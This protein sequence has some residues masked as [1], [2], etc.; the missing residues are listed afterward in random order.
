MDGFIARRRVL[1]ARYDEL[2]G[3]VS[4]VQPV[5]V[6]GPKVKSA[7]HLYSVLIDFSEIGCSRAECMERLREYGIGTQVH[8]IPVPSQPYYA[9]RG[10]AEVEFPGANGYYERTL[11]LPMFPSMSLQDLDR[12]VARLRDV[13]GC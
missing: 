6:E 7:Y 2:L 8:Y 12:V 1:A 9:K 10:W 3:T 5:T 4:A 13:L 11:S